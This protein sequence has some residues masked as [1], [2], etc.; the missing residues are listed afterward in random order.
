MF[1]RALLADGVMHSLDPTVSPLP[2]NEQRYAAASC[3]EGTTSSGNGSEKKMHK[4]TLRIG[5][6]DYDGFQQPTPACARAVRVA[7]AALEAKGH[8][9]VEVDMD[10]TGLG[11]E[12]FTLFAALI[13]SDQGETMK[14]NL[15]D[16]PV[17]PI[18]KTLLFLIGMPWPVRCVMAQVRPHAV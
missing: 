10:S 11:L 3:S 16:S 1:N 17:D 7:K 15:T 13:G 4:K 12:G 5:W 8:T 2:F 18:L 9:C 6:Y 14:G